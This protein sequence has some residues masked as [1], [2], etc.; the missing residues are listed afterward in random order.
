MISIVKQ[1]IEYFLR[2]WKKISII[3]LKIENKNLLNE[4][5]NCFVTIYSKWEIRW[6]SGNI[7]ELKDNSVEEIIENTFS[8]ISKDSRFS[9]LT[10]EESDNLKIRIDKIVKR[11]LLK[12]NK[13]INNIDP[14]KSWVIVI[15]TDYSK[16]ACILPNINP[17]L[18]SWE[19]FQKILKQKLWENT[20]DEKNF[21]IYEIKTEVFTNY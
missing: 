16:M 21:I 20:F 11:D 3:D 12:W 6:S 14:T 9:P 5:I 7:T 18:I 10:N 8:A 15:K 1:T 4:K 19:D 13:S 17:K 2:T